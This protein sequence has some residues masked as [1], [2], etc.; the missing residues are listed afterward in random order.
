[1]KQ[2]ECRL[3]EGVILTG[4]AVLL[5]LGA[6]ACGKKTVAPKEKQ[7]ESG[8]E[9]E[10]RESTEQAADGAAEKSGTGA[11]KSASDQ[12]AGGGTGRV[13][14]EVKIE[15]KQYTAEDGTPIFMLRIAYPVL[16]GEDA[17]K[18][19]IN[20]Y[21][22][23]WAQQ[24]LA[25][26]ERDENSTRQ[27]ALEVYRESRDSGWAGPWGEQYELESVKAWNGYLSIL[28][29]SYLYEGAASGTPYREGL[30]FRLSDGK[31]VKISEM[32]ALDAGEW[33]KI[34]R[35]RFARIVAAGKKD[36]FYEDAMEQVMERDMSDVGYFFTE[37]GIAF[38]LPPYEIAPWSTGYVVA[39][40]PYEEI[41][42][43]NRPAGGAY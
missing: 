2:R 15:E 34:L 32:T 22:E 42:R 7:T 18:E 14:Y 25:G 29:D 27:S 41:E 26:Y 30:V 33:D 37:D 23:Q 21:L 6:G 20:H 40:I 4:L 8:Q 28:I 13:T 1:M 19:K 11:D 43:Y 38:Y 9:T 24:K 3:A 35:A 17:G 31:K 10:S 12:L 39:E 16:L 36:A 5:A